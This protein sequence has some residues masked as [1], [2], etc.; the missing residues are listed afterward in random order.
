[1]DDQ[2][3]R[4]DDDGWLSFSR[5]VILIQ[6]QRFVFFLFFFLLC[7][8]QLL[9]VE[10]RSGASPLHGC[11]LETT[12]GSTW[13]MDGRPHCIKLQPGTVSHISD[14]LHNRTLLLQLH[15]LDRRLTD[16]LISQC[17]RHSTCTL[18]IFTTLI[19]ATCSGVGGWGGGLPFNQWQERNDLP[20]ASF[21]QPACLSRR[22]AKLQSGKPAVAAQFTV[23]LI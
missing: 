16:S 22:P 11:H 1:M 20:V 13:W 15:L 9:I 4:L 2:W 19:W 23:W 18:I 14:N 8:C 3:Q 5:V 17:Q 21:L 12:A 6:S 7:K 10:E